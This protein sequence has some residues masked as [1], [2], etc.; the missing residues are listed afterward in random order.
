MIESQTYSKKRIAKNHS[1]LKKSNR[2]VRSNCSGNSTQNCEKSCYH[3]RKCKC[4][5][6]FIDLRMD[7]CKQAYLIQAHEQPELLVRLV[8][9]LDSEVSYFYIHVD[10]KAKKQFMTDLA[11]QNLINKPNVVFTKSINVR[12]A[13]ISQCESIIILLRAVNENKDLDRIHFIS[14]TDYPIKSKQEFNRFFLNNPH[15]YI[16][17]VPAESETCKRLVNHYYFVYGRNSRAKFKYSWQYY[18]AWLAQKTSAFLSEYLGLPIRKPFSIKYY[19]GQCWFSI[20]PETASLI[21]RYLDDNPCLLNRFKYTASSD[22][23]LFI[24]IMMANDEIRK[25]IVNDGLRL[26]NPDGT[27]FRGGPALELKDLDRIK[28][29]SAFFARKFDLHKS[30]DLMDQID[31][32]IL[33]INAE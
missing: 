32:Q 23:S 28:K 6:I 29:N 22:E 21:L 31:I 30:K 8:E 16:S 5:L 24:M 14:G 27:L 2:N 3:L 19:H 20:K 11:V 4:I 17:Y 9:R 1:C 25:N 13:D 18:I 15:D 12:W 33:G 26:K 10:S 7:S